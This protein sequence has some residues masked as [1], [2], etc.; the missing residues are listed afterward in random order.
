MVLADVEW[1]IDEATRPSFRASSGVMDSPP[2]ARFAEGNSGMSPPAH[3]AAIDRVLVLAVA[4]REHVR[5]GSL[6]VR[7]THQ[8]PTAETVRLY[9]ADKSG[10][11]Q[12]RIAIDMSASRLDVALHFDPAP[13]V[14]ASDLLRVVEWMQSIALGD[15]LELWSDSELTPLAA[16]S[17]RALDGLSFPA[18]YVE[19]VKLLGRIQRQIG[20]AVP[21][22]D[23]LRARE[24]Q[25]AEGVLALLLGETVHAKWFGATVVVDETT[26]RFFETPGPGG[27]RFEVADDEASLDRIRSGYRFPVLRTFMQARVTSITTFSNLW[28]VHLEPGAQHPEA[29]TRRLRLSDI[30]MCRGSWIADRDGLIVAMGDAPDDVVRR[31]RLT[32]ESGA[33][34][35]VPATR[36]E[37]ESVWA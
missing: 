6:E 29:A 14:D 23:S 27:F 31:L 36:Q 30:D 32:N 37:A 22:P 20:L 35:R 17:T 34:W 13:E 26:R 8:A 10:S 5:I 12:V 16:A 28:A 4:D 18:G 2:V 7:F 24:I 25:A 33:I 3:S 19:T 1:E 21:V 15:R 11:L 9:G